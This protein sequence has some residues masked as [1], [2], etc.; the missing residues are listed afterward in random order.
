MHALT[1]AVYASVLLASCLTASAAS[2]GINLGPTYLTSACATDSGEGFTF[3]S[4]KGSKEYSHYL[5]EVQETQAAGSGTVSHD[6]VSVRAIFRDALATV[7]AASEGVGHTVEIGIIS[8]PL[9]FNSSTSKVLIDAAKDLQTAWAGPLTRFTN[10]GRLAYG[11]NSCEGF[12]MNS[13]T[14]D[15]EDGEHSVIVVDYNANYLEVAIGYVRRDTCNVR[16]YKRVKELGEDYRSSTSY[17]ERV[18]KLLQEFR[19]AYF[20]TFDFW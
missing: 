16:G 5:A 8:Q 15:I 17:Q 4:V 7:I 9:Y 2:I 10:A 13:S 11:L 3:V 19:G 6:D 18:Q 14:C 1:F 20:A 12:G